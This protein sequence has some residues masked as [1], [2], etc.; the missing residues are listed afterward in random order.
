MI[1]FRIIERTIISKLNR[2]SESAFHERRL[3]IGSFSVCR[4]H[5]LAGR[6]SKAPNNKCAHA[7]FPRFRVRSTRRLKLPDLVVSRRVVNPVKTVR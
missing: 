1:D 5:N 3:E 6:Q 4:G 7:Y 2:V